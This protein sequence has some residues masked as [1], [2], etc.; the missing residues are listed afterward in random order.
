[1]SQHARTRPRPGVRHIPA[2]PTPTQGPLVSPALHGGPKRPG[3]P[4]TSITELKDL[5]HNFVS[6]RNWAQ[7]HTAKSLSIAIAVEAAELMDLLKWYSDAEATAR[8]Q[9]G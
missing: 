3:D 7:F 2:R 9:R 4:T 5:V 6:Q 8:V 1:M